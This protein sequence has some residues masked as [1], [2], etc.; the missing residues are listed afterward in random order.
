IIMSFDMSF[1][2]GA[3]W[4]GDTSF[5]TE[6]SGK[7]SESNKL[8]DK[9]PIPAQISHLADLSDEKVVFGSMMFASA[10]TIGDVVDVLGD[11]QSKQYKLCDPQNPDATFTVMTYE[12]LSE[13]QGTGIA[14]EQGQRI[15][16]AGK[17]RSFDGQVMIVTFKIR[18]LENELEYDCFVKEAE[19]AK[20]YWEKNVQTALR[21]GSASSLAGCAAGQP[22]AKDGSVASS[23]YTST[24]SRPVGSSTPAAHRPAT[25]APTTGAYNDVRDQIMVLL[26][27]QKAQAEG[28]DN[29][30]KDL[31]V[32]QVAN[33]LKKSEA[34]IRN[35]MDQ[36]SQDGIIYSTADDD[37]FET[38]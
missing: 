8:A 17:L 34:V 22:M 16:A 11:G 37:H 38:L 30:R 29:E 2:D 15:F 28:R 12:G 9:L 25:A 1:G 4:G 19:I 27:K 6:T 26:E 3:G 10:Y 36:L 32:E 31:S 23:S 18:H 20:L 33:A 21:N 35:A 24:G 13:E 14:V 7:D 5:A